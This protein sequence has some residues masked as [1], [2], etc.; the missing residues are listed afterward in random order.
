V[1]DIRVTG[2][3]DPRM[4]TLSAL[5]RRGYPPAAL[6]N[7]CTDIGVSKREQTIEFNRLEGAVRE[8]LNKT[9]WRV[10]AV[11][12]PLKVVIKNYP[13]GQVEEM[14][15]INN[16]EDESA[17]KRTVPFSKTLH[18]ERDDFMEDPPK[19][20][21]RLAPGREVR[22]RYGYWITCTDVVKNDAGEII[23]IHATYDPATRGGDNP[24]DGRKVKGTIHWVSAEHAYAC[25]VRLYDRLYKAPHPGR[26]TGNFL[27]DINP[28]A[29][30]VIRAYLEPG[31]KEAKAGDRFQFE[32]HGYFVADPKDSKSDRPL[33]NR[34]V[35][36]RD[37][38]AAKG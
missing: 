16:P 26:E 19:K 34:T 5:R 12:D 7:F 35:T 15:A 8:E 20:F 13:D 30:T 27:D 17:G 21:F 28:N 29:K 10:M 32:R 1:D 37:S 38:W 33:F 25:E 4:P 36:L 14:D 11:L 3:I 23:E 9:A 2:C 22:L 24:P 6:V 18:I 31:L